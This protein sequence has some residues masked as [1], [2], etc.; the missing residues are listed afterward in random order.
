M[1]KVCKFLDGSLCLTSLEV[2]TATALLGFEVVSYCEDSRAHLL[3]PKLGVQFLYARN[4][5]F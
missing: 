3:S 1:G 2:Y 5:N 4:M